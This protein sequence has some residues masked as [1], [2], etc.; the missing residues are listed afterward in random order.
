MAGVTSKKLFTHTQ[1]AVQTDNFTSNKD[2]LQCLKFVVLEL[3][4][5]CAPASLK[6][7]D[8]QIAKST[9][10]SIKLIG[11]DLQR[12]QPTEWN[13]FMIACIGSD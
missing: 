8:E 1:N 13:D 11:C 2:F 9:S 5:K 12:N 7:I 6:T 3:S 4:G 10:K